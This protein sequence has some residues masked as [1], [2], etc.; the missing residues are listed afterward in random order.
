VYLTGDFQNTTDFDPGTGTFTLSTSGTANV[1]V[2]KL[3]NLTAS[4]SQEFN[5]T[6]QLISV[7][8]NPN[9][10]QFEIKLKEVIQ[11]AS[12]EI[13][14]VLGETILTKN[15]TETNNSIQVPKQC[16]GIYFIKILANT[17]VI[18]IKK[19]VLEGND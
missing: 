17:K 19:I 12:I 4:I 16:K 9:Q 3:N 14:N 15:I 7:Y 11:N 1:F 10:G 13:L 5:S 6:Q 8:P 2:C 18:A